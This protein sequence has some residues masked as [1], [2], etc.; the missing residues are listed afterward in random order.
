MG[1]SLFKKKNKDKVPPPS[2][3]T[4]SVP[5]Q[6]L[7]A[8]PHLRTPSTSSLPGSP[9]LGTPST[10]AMNSPALSV[11]EWGQVPSISNGRRIKLRCVLD[12]LSNT[13]GKQQQEVNNKGE[14]LKELFYITAE[15]DAPVETL[16]HQIEAELAVEGLHSVGVFKVSV[17]VCTREGKADMFA[18]SRSLSPGQHITRP[19]R[20][21]NDMPCRLT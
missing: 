12:P 10:P 16:R 1:F 8:S 3:S 4:L 19:R 21:P 14:A 9:R 15:L 6:R 2:P 11:N 20:T 18:F 17:R 7:T 5:A 13:T